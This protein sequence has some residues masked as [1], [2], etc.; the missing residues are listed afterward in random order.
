MVR[1]DVS[2]LGYSISGTLDIPVW[3]WFSTQ[4]RVKQSEIQRDAA[5]VTLTA[6]QRRLI[7]TLEETYAEAAAA[8]NQLD[9]LD[10]SVR[11]AAESLRLTKLA[12]CGGRIH[13]ARS[14]RCPELLSIRGD[15]SSRW[16]CSLSIRS[17][18]TTAFDGNTMSQPLNI[19]IRSG[20]R[21]AWHAASS[22]DCSIW[23]VDSGLQ[24]RP[25]TAMT[26]TLVT[27]Q[28]ERPEVGDISEHIMA[29]ATLSPLAQAAISPK[30]TA[31]V[32]AFYVQRG[33]KVKAGDLLG[34]AREPRSHRTGTGQQGAVRCRR[35]CLQH[36][37]KGA[38][39]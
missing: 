22:S 10:Q 14:G 15:G 1:D 8:Q 28:A 18:G 6:A 35:S 38:G 34:R 25:T 9:L 21:T 24:E 16:C 33:S 11:T 7:A 27:V 37:D 2:N 4:K 12:L 13:C 26:A 30:I 19:S 36:A 5:K 23:P 3:D 20:I 32:R 17:C 31:P 39:S 29:D